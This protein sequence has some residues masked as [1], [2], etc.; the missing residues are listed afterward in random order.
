M[1]TEVSAAAQVI[2]SLIPIVGISF[3]AILIFFF[4][5]WH[6]REVKLRILKG[7]SQYEPT[8]IDPKTLTL[9][10]GLCLSGTGAVLSIMSFLLDGLSWSALGGLLPLVLGLMLLLFYK[11]NPEFNDS[12]GNE[13]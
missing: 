1:Q 6:H 12:N 7:E 9:L 4:M 2:I 10:I 3:A 11:T 13:E 5:L 8:K